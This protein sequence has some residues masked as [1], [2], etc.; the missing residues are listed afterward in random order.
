MMIVNG[1]GVCFEDDVIQAL[2]V[3]DILLKT[4]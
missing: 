4:L 2:K 3:G 1:R